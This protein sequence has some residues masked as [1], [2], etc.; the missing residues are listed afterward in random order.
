MV[1]VI[2]ALIVAA[3]P[4]LFAQEAW[5]LVGLMGGVAVLVNWAYLSPRARALRWL[6][7]GLIFMGLFVVWPVFYTAYVSLTNWQTGNI[8]SKDQVIA[9]L[10][11]EVI[12]VAGGGTTL[13]LQVFRD[14]GGDL[15]FYLVDPE[16]V[17]YFGS[18]RDRDAEPLVDPLIDPAQLGIRDDD[19][20]GLPEAIG[21]FE[22]LR[23]RDLFTIA[24]E[25]ERLVLDI[26]GQGI[27]QVQTTSQ[28]RLIA[29]GRRYTYD[30]TT[31]TLYD[32]Q[33]G[34]TCV[35]E[36]GNFVCPDGRRIDPGWRTVV[37]VGNFQ[38]IFSNRDIRQPF[39]KVFVWNL[40]FAAMSVVLTFGAGLALANAMQ[41]GRMRGKAFYRS[42]Y[43]IPYAIPA[44]I[45]AIVWRGLL[46]DTIGQVNRLLDTVGID[47][48]P[49]LQSPFWAK[50]ALLL[51]NTWLGFPYMFLIA[52]GAL[53]AIPEELKEAARVDGASGWRVFRTVTL[54][55]LLV[56]TTPLLIG[57]F[58][59]N[60]N[61]FVLIFLLTNGGPPVPSTAVPVGETDIL[62]TFTFDL[63]VQAGRGNRFSL[64][65]AIII[66]I[67]VI[68]AGISASS[69]R[70]TRRLEE[71]YGA[72]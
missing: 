38:D 52:T 60:F 7:P 34:V 2:D 17:V 55:L 63:A 59:F 16:G 49:W 18:P 68:V 27:A 62:I 56:S 71:T 32:A 61:N 43:I 53:Q 54:P 4:V 14:A 46:N 35:V 44:F 57:S 8:L 30:A 70:A 45:S 29:G 25:L 69:F 41:H 50:V 39:F 20:D 33:E 72:L 67:F 28:A 22:R 6:A 64:G 11:D 19:G 40:I 9:D 15:R 48:P 10:E 58:A 36:V 26:P 65:S 12:R 13:G 23:L 5:V 42:I 21:P 24:G 37:G 3:L 31:D 1:A 51:V 66:L 47:G